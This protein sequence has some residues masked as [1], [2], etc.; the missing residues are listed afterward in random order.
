MALSQHLP[1]GTEETHEKSQS[2]E[3]MCRVDPIGLHPQL[4]QLTKILMYSSM[5][6]S[7]PVLGRP[8]DLFP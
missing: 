6:L 8:V 7:R 2:G 5:W 3:Y 4:Y 1:G